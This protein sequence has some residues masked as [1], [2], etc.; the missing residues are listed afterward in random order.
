MVVVPTNI[1]HRRTVS[2]GFTDMLLTA[3]I[4][5]Q[6]AVVAY[7]VTTTLADYKHILSSLQRQAKT[8]L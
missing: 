1:E 3:L 6:L 5:Y 7:H 8:D 4:N 2:Y